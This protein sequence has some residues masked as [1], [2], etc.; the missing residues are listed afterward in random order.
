MDRPNSG[1][2]VQ[3]GAS[4]AVTPVSMASCG[5]VADPMQ[6]VLEDTEVVL[7]MSTG[8]IVGGKVST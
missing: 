6:A 8:W 7:E 5:I 2:L 3:A 1:L 4:L